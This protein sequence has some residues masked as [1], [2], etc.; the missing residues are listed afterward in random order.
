MKTYFK[1]PRFRCVPAIPNCVHPQ[2]S[3]YYYYFFLSLVL[4]GNAFNVAR[5]GAHLARNVS[6]RSLVVQH[7]HV[8][9]GRQAPFYF[10]FIREILRLSFSPI[11]QYPV[12]GGVEG[13]KEEAGNSMSL[14][15]SLFSFLL[16][17]PPAGKKGKRS[18]HWF[19]GR[20]AEFPHRKLK[21]TRKVPVS[22]KMYLKMEICLLGGRRLLTLY[23]V[24]D[25]SS[26][27]FHFPRKRKEEKKYLLIV[28]FFPLAL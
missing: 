20:G 21:K 3:R 10:E 2:S 19:P 12:G 18:R 17:L 27:A 1:S 15:I 11:S 7:M 26:A 13:R 8:L 23:P 16:L 6:G 22:P 9:W 25:F 5:R 28:S 4:R 24:L 14:S